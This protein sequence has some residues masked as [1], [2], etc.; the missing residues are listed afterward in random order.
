MEMEMEL[1]LELRRRAVRRRVRSAHAAV[2]WLLGK[3]RAGPAVLT[4]LSP[5]GGAAAFC[6]P[7]FSW[8]LSNFEMLIIIVI[9]NT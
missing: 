9:S 2:G 5:T 7:L 6:L 8:L 4:R 1:E 3:E